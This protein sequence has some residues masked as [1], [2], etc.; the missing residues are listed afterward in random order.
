MIDAIIASRDLATTEVEHRLVE[1]VNELQ[2]PNGFEE[3]W[4]SWTG[5]HP[6]HYEA[7]YEVGMRTET[8]IGSTRSTS[9]E[10]V[11]LLV[12]FWRRLTRRSREYLPAPKPSAQRLDHYYIK[13]LERKITEGRHIEIPGD[14][15][16][17]VRS[18]I[19]EA[20]E[21]KWVDRDGSIQEDGYS[22]TFRSQ[23]SY[24]RGG[25][26]PPSWLSIDMATNWNL[27]LSKAPDQE[28]LAMRRTVPKLRDLATAIHK[29][30]EADRTI[31]EVM[32]IAMR[33]DGLAYKTEERSGEA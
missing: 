12:R 26:E 22:G 11:P 2:K 19:E 6:A 1:Y 4:P 10:H 30:A 15:P 32:A 16:E 24:T 29:A 21:S 5:R 28:W 31:A 14:C 9:R 7:H 20:M 25:T 27:L 18:L 8:D 13:Y 33:P 17:P 23:Y 3:T